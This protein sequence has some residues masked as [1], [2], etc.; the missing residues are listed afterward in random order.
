[1]NNYEPSPKGKCPHC[2][3]EVEL[4]TVNK[5]IK[6]AGF[7]KQEIMYICPHCRSVLGFSRGKF[8]S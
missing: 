1:M 5:E 3:G 8:M 6:G 4:G 2:K 7:I